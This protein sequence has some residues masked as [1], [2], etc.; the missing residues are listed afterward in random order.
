MAGDERPRSAPCWPPSKQLTAFQ[1]LEQIR[2]AESLAATPI[3]VWELHLFLAFLDHMR[4][5]GEVEPRW[6]GPI[7]AAAGPLGR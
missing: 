5:E 6:R 2:G 1:L 4:I 7:P 3:A